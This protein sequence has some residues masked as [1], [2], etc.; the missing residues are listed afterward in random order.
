MKF[1][2]R[3]KA[4]VTICMLLHVSCALEP[5][6]RQPVTFEGPTGKVQCLSPPKEI[7][8]KEATA[9]T[10]LAVKKIG[11]LVKGSA[12]VKI[13]PERVRQEVTPE[14]ANWEV[15]DYRICT[16][17]AKGV[18]TREDYR[19][20]TRDI[21]PVLQENAGRSVQSGSQS[22]HQE[23]HGGASPATSHVNGDVNI[24]ITTPTK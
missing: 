15:I 14:V 21:L 9:Q 10:E 3:P 1:L 13:D 20:F 11:T 19:T 5:P 6:E 22:I 7:L 17:Y 12:G 18:L 8:N 2:C 4:L 16:Q 23:T 24:T